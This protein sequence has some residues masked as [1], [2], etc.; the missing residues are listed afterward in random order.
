MPKR[1]HEVKLTSQERQELETITSK[2]AVQ[3]RVYKRARI[4]LLADEGL[5][6]KQIVARV[7]SSRATVERIRKRYTQE[8]AQ[9]AITEKARPGRPSIFDGETRAKITALAC[10][11]APEGH[12]RWDLRLLADKAV[13]LGYVEGISHVTVGKILKKTNWHHTRSGSGV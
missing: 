12:A 4:L 1:L 13:E 2:G 7:G 3:V 9:S 5:C 6:D 10:S 11:T 8:K